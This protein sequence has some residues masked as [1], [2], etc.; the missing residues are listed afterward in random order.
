VK[1]AAASR[2]TSIDFRQT[3]ENTPVFELVALWNDVG[4]F[5]EMIDPGDGA[6]LGNL[7]QGS[8]HLALIGAALDLD[9][10]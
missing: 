6:F 7:P 10:A 9:D 3:N 5:A 8:S 4:V 1:T 2:S